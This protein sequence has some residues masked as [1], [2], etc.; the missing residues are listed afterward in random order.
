MHQEFAKCPNAD[1]E[2]VEK[3]GKIEN[4]ILDVL[5]RTWMEGLELELPR[6][7]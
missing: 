1:D 2:E 4:E 7:Y 5:E 6:G 3:Q